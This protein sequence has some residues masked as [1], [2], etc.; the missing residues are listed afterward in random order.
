M[1]I[2]SLANILG[3][4][5]AP[6]T[7]GPVDGRYVINGVNPAAV[8]ITAGGTAEN[9]VLTPSGSGFVSLVRS[10]AGKSL[11][12]TDG[13]RTFT[14]N[15]SSGNNSY[16]AGTSSNH[17]FD[18]LANDTAIATVL[19]DATG[20]RMIGTRLLKFGATSAATIGVS[21][22]TTAGNLVLTPAS[23]GG[24]VIGAT[25]GKSVVLGIVGSVTG[26]SAW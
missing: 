8:T 20:F 3:G 10:G 7:G 22:D 16:Q 11:T 6:S 13:T 25:S 17:N 23:A 26:L 5:Q 2:Q 4:Q 15:T 1:A 21:A 19:A 24:V 9:I 14:L 12:A 18:L